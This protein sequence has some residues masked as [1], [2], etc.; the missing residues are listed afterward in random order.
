MTIQDA[1][2]AK[3]FLANTRFEKLAKRPGGVARNDAIASASSNIDKIKPEVIFWIRKGS[4]RLDRA[5]QETWISAD[6]AARF[7]SAIELSASLR[8]IGTTVGFPL[9]SFI[10]GNL[11]EILETQKSGVKFRKDIIDVHRM[12]L[13]LSAQDDYRNSRPDDLP[14]F[15]SGFEKVLT[16]F[17]R[18][19]GTTEPE[20]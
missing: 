16:I 1:P 5:I 17:R 12:A 10:C 3:I 6:D 4:A 19:S 2:Q 9:L 14:I 7:D 8:D 15:K 13:T 11:C 20:S 18:E